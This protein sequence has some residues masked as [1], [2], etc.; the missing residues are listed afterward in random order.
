M[1]NE[2]KQA[3]REHAAR[4][5]KQMKHAATNAA[6][7]AEA[8]TETVKDEVV[9]TSEESYNRFKDLVSTVVSNEMSRGVILLSVGVI[10]SAVGVRTILS[11]R[12][13]AQD[14][15]DLQAS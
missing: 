1:S 15:A 14:F 13:I 10:F 2:S 11:A 7:A 9:D 12:G 8:A 6:E 4:A 5:T 3:A